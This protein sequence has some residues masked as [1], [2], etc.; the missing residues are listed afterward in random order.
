MINKLLYWYN[1]GGPK[2]K[3]GDLLRYSD[4][5]YDHLD[6]RVLKVGW[7]SYHVYF[8]TRFAFETYPKV[9]KRYIWSTDITHRV[10]NEN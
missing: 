9:Q 7:I 5:E 6:I 2:F 8:A 3:S 1:R 10:V 4:S